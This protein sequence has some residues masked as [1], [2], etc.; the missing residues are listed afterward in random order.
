MTLPSKVTKGHATGN[1]FVM[2]WDPDGK[3]EP[4][5]RQTR[6]L[7]DRHFGIGGDGLLRLVPLDLVI[8]LDANLLEACRAAG[9]EWFMDYRNADGSI[10]E[11]CGN[12]TRAI[13]LF[14][15]KLGLTKAAGEFKLATRAGLKT[16]T[17]LGD[18]PELGQD[19][20]RVEMGSFSIGEIGKYRVTIPGAAG[21]ASGTFV[22]MGN[23]HVVSVLGAT[24]SAGEEL[25]RPQFA[26]LAQQL[27][28]ASLPDVE[29][30]DLATKPVVDPAI[31][32]DQNVE[33]LAIRALEPEQDQGSAFMRVNER[34]VGETLSCGTGLCASGVV[35]QALTGIHQWMIAVRGGRLRV[36]V[37]DDSTVTLTG[38]ASIVGEVQLAR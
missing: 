11:M 8:G 30:L 22:D 26:A 14:A 18:V 7:C 23:P 13:T 15:Q 33:F 34:G 38:P 29:S 5:E 4:T 36:A 19:V 20:F 35:L 37:H 9:T 31:D 1:D 32:S 24:A 16:L 3:Y 25:G 6:W 21:Q 12:G 17:S 27:S 2:Y 10:A 28:A